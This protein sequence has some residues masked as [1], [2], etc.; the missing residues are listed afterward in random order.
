[1][2]KLLIA[3]CAACVT[4]LF[5]AS[6][7]ELE[8][9]CKNGNAVSCTELGVLYYE[10]DDVQQDYAKASE[11]F[12]KA[13]D[14]GYAQ[15]CISLGFLYANGDGVPQD[16]AKANELYKK[17]CDKGYAQGCTN[18]GFSYENGDGV[19]QNNAKALEFYTKSCDMGNNN[20]CYN[21]MSMLRKL[22]SDTNPSL[23]G[24][25]LG[26][27]TIAD[28]DQKHRLT[29]KGNG[30]SSITDGKIYDIDTKDISI[31]GVKSGVVIFEQDGT[32]AA[33]RLNINKNRFDA[34]FDQ[35]NSKYKLTYKEILAV[36]DKIAKFKAG[37]SEIELS[38]R[39]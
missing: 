7:A 19:K 8:K 25:Q 1:M 3:L 31:E 9:E 5:A 18:L 14:Q 15:G 33:V 6:I 30:F 27:S 20:G 39:I 35:L 17:V 16:Y 34:I 2:K 28:V 32:L 22:P 37:N 38:R 26:K 11:L 29:K 23:I 13:C 10:G 36:G 12:K 4:S 21:Q 24:L